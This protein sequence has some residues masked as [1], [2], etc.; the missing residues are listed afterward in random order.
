MQITPA[1]KQLEQSGCCPPQR[2]FCNLHRVHA[3]P[4]LRGGGCDRAGLM[5]MVDRA[6]F[7]SPVWVEP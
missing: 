7:V 5:F 3:E 4:R 1:F 6:F 2:I